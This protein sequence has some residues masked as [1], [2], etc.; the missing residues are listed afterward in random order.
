MALLFIGAGGHGRALLELLRDAGLP[1]PG[2]VLD[3]AADCP[4]LACPGLPPVPWLG[5]VARAAELFSRKD[6][7]SAHVALGRNALRRQ[8]GESLAAI[9]YALP[10]LR[11]PSAVI[12]GSARIGPGSAILPR[13]VVGAAVEVGTCAIL[14]T[15]SIAEHDSVIGPACHLAP[16]SV[17]GGGVRLGAEVLVGILAGVKPGLRIGDGA[18]IGMGS[19]VLADVAPGQEVG[20]VPARPL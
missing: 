14:N 17:L 2:G 13:A 19:A 7:D 8:V 9:G 5:P 15:G 12:A 6:F 11:H 10:V 16:G 4:G 1:P 3:D 18:V 20:G